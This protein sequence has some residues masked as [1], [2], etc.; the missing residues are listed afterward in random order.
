ME[1]RDAK[2]AELEKIIIALQA[3]I[4]ELRRRLNLNSGNSSKPP[5]SD[6]LRKKPAP[7]SLRETRGKKSGGQPGHKGATLEFSQTP[8]HTIN[9]YPETCECGADLQTTMIEPH[10][11][12]RQV[13]DIPQPKIE[14]TQHIL[15]RKVCQHCKAINK[16]KAPEAAPAPLNYGENIK[17]CAVYMQHLQMIPEDRLAQLF[18]DIFGLKIC[19]QTLVSCGVRLA[20]KL[21]PWYDATQIKFNHAAVRHADESGFRIAGKT[22]W[23]HSLSTTLATLYRPEK[24]RGAIPLDL[25]TQNKN[26]RFMQIKNVLLGG[27]CYP[28]IHSPP[29]SAPFIKRNAGQGLW[30]LWVTQYLHHSGQADQLA[31]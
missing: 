1:E 5:S 22:A 18:N 27:G 8:D 26:V 2:I 25:S 31:R 29:S 11:E 28:Q 30:S 12:K 15:H 3:E 7:Q 14:V 4:K 6:G 9:H 13:F 20:E 10:S 16:A 24:K 17:G 21:T 19:P 23:L